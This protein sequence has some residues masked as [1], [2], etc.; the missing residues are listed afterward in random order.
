MDRQIR[1]KRKRRKW[2]EEEEEKNKNVRGRQYKKYLV[3]LYYTVSSTGSST[4]S[5]GFS[6]GEVPVL[7]ALTVTQSPNATP[8]PS[9][10][11]IH[12]LCPRFYV[13]FCKTEVSRCSGLWWFCEV[14][15]MAS[16]LEAPERVSLWAW[17]LARERFLSGPVSGQEDGIHGRYEEKSIQVGNIHQES[18]NC[19]KT[20]QAHTG[21]GFIGSYNCQIQ[22]W[23]KCQPALILRHT[24]CPQDLLTHLCQP[25][26]LPKFR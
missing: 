6:H 17:G 10:Q 3:S 19:N 18:L 23:D 21:K 11:I 13:Q 16:T 26:H 9:S 2:K 15:K 22:N 25:L 8:L 24:Y 5:R 1:K 12:F 4:E 14:G 7:T 20:T